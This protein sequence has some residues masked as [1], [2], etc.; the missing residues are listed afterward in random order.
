VA[1]FEGLVADDDTCRFVALSYRTY[2]ELLESLDQQPPW[3]AEH[4]DEARR[5]YS[6]SI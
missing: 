5:R 3:L 1:A 6:V 2:W 4:L